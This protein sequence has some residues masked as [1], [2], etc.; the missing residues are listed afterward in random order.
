MNYIYIIIIEIIKIIRV[1]KVILEI[2]F[3]II[4]YIYPVG[5]KA[6]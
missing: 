2:Y 5:R 1:I 4:V 6:E 3:D